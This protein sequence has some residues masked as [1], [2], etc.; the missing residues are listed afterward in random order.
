MVAASSSLLPNPA[1]QRSND[2]RPPADEIASRA[3]AETSEN[4]R[5]AM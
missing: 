3:I 1:F 4:R 2:I 5:S